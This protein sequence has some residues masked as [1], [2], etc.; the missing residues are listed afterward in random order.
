M[1]YL[2]YHDDS[3]RPAERFQTQPAQI[4]V[5]AQDYTRDVPGVRLGTEEGVVV[6]AGDFW[7]GPVP[8]GE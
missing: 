8:V 4:L 6:Q 7:I 2:L 5:N 1:N 3:R